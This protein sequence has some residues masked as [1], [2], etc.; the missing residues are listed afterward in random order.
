MS[1]KKVLLVKP[2]GRHGLSYA[3]DLI[4]TGLEYIASN[5]EDV[6]REVTILDLEMERKPMEKVMEMSLKSLDPDLVGISMSATDHRE[7][8][9]IARLAKA[10]GATTVL[11]GYHPTAIPEKLLSKPQMDMV[12]RG[13]GEL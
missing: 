6:V 7:G 13:E 12:V 8:L 5:I 1:F 3:F 11:G 4:P 9:D 2:S 10:H